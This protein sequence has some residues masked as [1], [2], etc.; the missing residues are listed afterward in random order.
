LAPPYIGPRLLT[1]L[2]RY[3][4]VSVETLFVDPLVNLLEEGLNVAI[5]IRELPEL[6]LKVAVKR[7]PGYRFSPISLRHTGWCARLSIDGPAPSG[8][9]RPRMRGLGTDCP[10][11]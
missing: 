4:E 5:R 10:L 9:G 2:E 11:G 1:F 3:P 8:T 7:Q 6:S